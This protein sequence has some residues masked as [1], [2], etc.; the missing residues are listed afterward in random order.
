MLEPYVGFKIVR[1]RLCDDQGDIQGVIIRLVLRDLILY[2]VS[3][4]E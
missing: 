3:L 4:E 2:Q 1:R